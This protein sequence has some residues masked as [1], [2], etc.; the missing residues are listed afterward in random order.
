MIDESKEQALA[1]ALGRGEAVGDVEIGALIESHRQMREQHR[2]ILN[3]EAGYIDEIQG[4]N[5]L[6]KELLDYVDAIADVVADT[7]DS[8]D[9]PNDIKKRA[10]AIII[11]SVKHLKQQKGMSEGS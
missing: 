7:L 3:L 1:E 6:V 4:L 5:G 9:V 2:M 8:S 11:E 10:V